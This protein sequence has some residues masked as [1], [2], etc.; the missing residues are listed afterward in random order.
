MKMNEKRVIQSRVF[1][2]K[3]DIKLALRSAGIKRDDTL[4]LHSS[5]SSMGWV[6]GASQTLI[7]ALLETLDL[8]T[9]CMPAYTSE[10]TDPSEWINPA[11]PEEWFKLIRENTPVFDKKKS[12]VQRLGRVAKNFKN[13]PE[14]L[15]SNHP[16]L[17]FCAYGK[18]A[19]FITKNHS[20]NFGFGDNSPLKKMEDLDAS[21]LLLGVDYDSC[22][23]M[24]LGEFRSGIRKVKKEA[25]AIIE[26]GIRIWKEYDEIDYD[27]DEFFD[28]GEILEEKAM[29]KIFNIGNAGCGLLK[30][31]DAVR[32]ATN[33]FIKKK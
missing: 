2:S 6:C 12:E 31:K 9:L 3:N 14:V 28:I 32:E 26:N 8:G 13:Y 10:N 18:H 24:H 23:A 20:L 30:L 17:S 33:Y 11:V 7:D 22:S 29:V 21:I 1:V 27:N 5:L 4:M 19:E 16:A 25:S 15:R